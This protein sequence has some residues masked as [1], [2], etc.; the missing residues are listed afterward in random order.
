M[1]ENNDYFTTGIKFSHRYNKPV[2]TKYLK[3]FFIF[4]F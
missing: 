4:Y 3:A 1:K 2:K